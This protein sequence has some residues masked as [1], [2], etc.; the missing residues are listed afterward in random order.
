MYNLA[1]WFQGEA[2][3]VVATWALWFDILKAYPLWICIN[4]WL[5]SYLSSD[6]V[7]TVDR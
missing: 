7:A 5:G 4:F 2:K 6:E 3:K 1:M